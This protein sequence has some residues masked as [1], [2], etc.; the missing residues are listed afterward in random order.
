MHADATGRGKLLLALLA[1]AAIALIIAR[2]LGI[3]IDPPYGIVSRSGTFLTD[4]GWWTKN[5]QLW[6]KFGV[7]RNEY[8]SNLVVNSIGFTLLMTAIFELFSTNL[9]V[10]RYAA[11]SASALS[12]LVLYAIARRFMSRESSLLVVIASAV[13]LHQV[14]YARMA[15]IESFATLWSILAIYWLVTHRNRLPRQAMSLAFAVLAVLTK[16]TFIFTLGTVALVLAVGAIGQLRRGGRAAAAG[17]F[18]CIVAAFAAVFAVSAYVGYLFPEDAIVGRFAVADR[19]RGF[20]IEQALA[21]ESR[22]W[23]YVATSFNW[24]VL[25]ATIGI[26]FV[27]LGA[28]RA[29]GGSRLALAPEAQAVL[30]WLLAGVFMFGAFPYSPPRYFYFVSLAAPLMALGLVEEAT[31]AHGRRALTLTVIAGVVA[32]HALSQWPSYRAWYWRGGSASF[33]QMA[34][35]FASEVIRDTGPPHEGQI[36]VMGATS[37]VLS[38][39]A[40]RIRPTDFGPIASFPVAQSKALIGRDDDVCARVGFWKPRFTVGAESTLPKLDEACP[41]LVEA[42][43][44][45]GRRRVMNGWYYKSD[46]VLRR[47]RYRPAAGQ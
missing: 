31:R 43:D 28:R 35:A 44:E 24:R 18:A 4:E 12:L 3:A 17:T 33:T 19:F 39:F 27:W 45:I 36:V 21:N 13:S 6:A 5:A 32:L 38:L 8:D 14:T 20:T 41:L 1:S 26:G 23:L 22:A 40:D 7:P 34:S 46:F 30:I 29:F 2:Y 15:I 25:F 10:A 47:V 11:V 9:L 16:S 37:S 42:E